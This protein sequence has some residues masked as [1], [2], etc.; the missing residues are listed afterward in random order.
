M[1]FSPNEI[2]GSVRIMYVTK[3][4]QEWLENK[5]QFIVGYK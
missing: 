5:C 2:K 4:S 1:Y 3:A